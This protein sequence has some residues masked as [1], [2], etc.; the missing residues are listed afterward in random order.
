MKLEFENNV[1]KKDAELSEL[2]ETLEMNATQI[3][4]LKK[5]ESAL[6]LE[7]NIKSEELSRRQE[8]LKEARAENDK[9][10]EENM[11]MKRENF[12]LS[13]KLEVL[14]IEYKNKVENEN[15]IKNQELK[16]LREKENEYKKIIG[17]MK[18]IIKK[19]QVIIENKKKMNLLLVDLAKIK[20]GE[21]QCL[22]TMHYTNSEKLKETLIKIRENE[23]DILSK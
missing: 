9:L 13:S 23:K 14:E 18:E 12:N 4:R 6:K 21:V 11:S 16:L 15:K 7:M 8:M 17:D 3:E 22:E 2:K 1:K 20:K 5:M 10:M 19:K